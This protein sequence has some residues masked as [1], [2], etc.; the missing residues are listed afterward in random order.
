[1]FCAGVEFVHTTRTHPEAWRILI[2]DLR[3]LYSGPVTYA[4]NWG[5]EFEKLAFADELDAVGINCYYPLAATD[6]AT[7]TELRAAFDK[8]CDMI[9]AQA[10]RWNKP[11]LFTEIGFRSIVSPWKHPHAEPENDRVN[12]AHQARC[13]QV[14]TDALQ[15]RDWCRGIYWWKWPSY[16]GYTAE[17]PQCYAPLGKPAEGII[18]AFYQ[19][20]P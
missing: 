7:D 16:L 17:D 2:R 19:Q 9:G 10:T 18:S 8:V 20:I 13:Y 11:I 4:A 14:V 12:H 15:G 5:E 3:Q 1:M 6:S